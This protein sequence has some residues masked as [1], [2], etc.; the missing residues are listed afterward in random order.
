VRLKFMQ[1]WC[2][3]TLEI[4]H[5]MPGNQYGGDSATVVS[6]AGLHRR[7]KKHRVRGEWFRW[8]P[9]IEEFIKPKPYPNP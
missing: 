5:T 8:C 9:E 4:I 1:P 2:V 7:F 3:N 6:E